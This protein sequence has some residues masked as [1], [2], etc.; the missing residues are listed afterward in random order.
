MSF[1]DLAREIRDLI[2]HGLLCSPEGVYLHHDCNRQKKMV[3]GG[4][5]CNFDAYSDSDVDKEEDLNDGKGQA[6][7]HKGEGLKA[8]D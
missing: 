7:V 6:E 8:T 1:S 2:Y 5:W 4:A 3:V